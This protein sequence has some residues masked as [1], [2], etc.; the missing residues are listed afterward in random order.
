MR[1]SWYRLGIHITMDNIIVKC[2]LRVVRRSLVTRFSLLLILY[3]PQRSYC[4]KQSSTT[5]SL[6]V[7]MY[8]H[9]SLTPPLL[10]AHAPLPDV[11]TQPINELTGL[12]LKWEALLWLE[13][14][15]DIPQTSGQ[16]LHDGCGILQVRWT[17][18]IQCFHYQTTC[19]QLS[20]VFRCLSFS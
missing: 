16:T 2:P 8:F 3:G 9:P 6:K 20:P 19:A 7:M 17:W 5:L 1:N 4:S 14:F 10:H 18:E 15:S 12:V 11:G 13:Y